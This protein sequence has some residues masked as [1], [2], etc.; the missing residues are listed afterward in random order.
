M[1]QRFFR[2]ISFFVGFSACLGTALAQKTVPNEFKA[3]MEI[4][5]VVSGTFGELR[6][7]HFHSGVD[8]ATNGQIGYKVVAIA[9]GYVSRIKISPIGYGKAVYITHPNGY[10]SV[11]G[12]LERFSAKIDSIAMARQYEK[13]RFEIDE[14]FKP[15]VMSV[16]AGEVVGLSGNTGSSGGPHLHFEV[17][18]TKTEKALNPLLFRRDAA[19]NVAPLIQGIRLYPQGDGARINASVKAVYYKVVKV[20][21]DYK[22][23]GN[24]V[25]T[26]S[27]KIGIGIEAIDFVSGS[28]RKCGVYSI[29]LQ[30]N[31]KTVFESVMD[32]FFFDQTRYINSYI[33]YAFKQSSGK[34]VM[35][36]FVEPNNK[37]NVYGVLEND[38]FIEILPGATHEMVYQVADIYGNKSKL[39]FKLK[40]TNLVKE[41]VEK[42]DDKLLS[43]SKSHE[44]EAEGIKVNIPA[45]CFY[46]NVSFP[47]MVISKG[48]VGNVWRVGDRSVPLHLPVSVN[49]K[50]PQKFDGYKQQVCMAR[51][52]ASGKL[53]YVTGSYQFGWVNAMVRET[54]DY[55]LAIDTVAPSVSIKNPMPENNY[56]GKAALELTV[57][58]NF[59]GVAEYNGFIDDAWALL[60]YDPKTKR[61]LCPLN[62]I[63]IEK[64][65]RHS[66][67]VV[68]KDACG[69]QTVKEWKFTY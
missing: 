64:N 52:D 40:G 55:T 5:P 63:P 53:N 8:F 60:E 18:D 32:G 49:I 65:K 19:D 48:P 47:F 34:S 4:S 43:F 36:S 68:I 30:M 58:D 46:T 69:N 17:R 12:H 57:V 29:G 45:N 15:S 33:D 3:P 6:P 20:N 56:R 27:G 42:K 9:E 59:S 39:V 50:V 37:L 26:A 38:G 23:E 41:T 28:Y 62:R 1:Q 2:G 22:I 11:Y 16:K 54:G 25:L 10:T 21:N 61:L 35:K 14:Y 31:G 51:K 7:N 44:I 24:P 67:R 13:Q 66:L